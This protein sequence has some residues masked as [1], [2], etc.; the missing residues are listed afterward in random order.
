[1]SAR[2]T[3]LS[4][5]LGAVAWDAEHRYRPTLMG[6]YEHKLAGVR[7][8][9]GLGISSPSAQWVAQW[10]ATKGAMKV[11]LELP[12]AAATRALQEGGYNPGS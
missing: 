3:T 7:L 10:Q 5:L 9:L 8:S 12:S 6:F 11:R 1:M 2:S 4:L